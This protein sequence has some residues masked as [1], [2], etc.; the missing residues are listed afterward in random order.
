ML[1]ALA[2]KARVGKDTIGKYL[3]EQYGFAHYY[4]AKPLKQMLEA[5]LDLPEQAFQSTEDKERILPRFGTSYR[6]LAQT[7][8]T[9]W[10]RE[11][12]KKLSGDEDLWVK[13]AAQRW[14]RLKE[15]MTVDSFGP[16]GMVLT[17]CR[18][19]NE[20]AWVRSAGGVVVHVLS[21]N[22][23]SGMTAE[24]SEHKSEKGVTF[25][26]SYSKPEGEYI[27]DRL[28]FNHFDP[29]ADRAESLRQLYVSV[30][31]LVAGLR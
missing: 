18:F 30:D 14:Q 8:G 21:K 17:D 19:E 1:V 26:Q 27:G 3:V 20:A 5:G 31:A 6:R 9:E 10:G 12:V 23:M 22:E 13:V 15:E 16:T 24:S 4:F 11:A 29:A 7:I 25:V 2:G 28:L